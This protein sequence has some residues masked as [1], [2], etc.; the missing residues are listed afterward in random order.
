MKH[1]SLLNANS[2][3]NKN[4]T[5]STQ[6]FNA[7]ER[8][9]PK[10]E[11]LYKPPPQDS[12][13][14]P[15][16]REPVTFAN[17]A[18]T[19]VRPVRFESQPTSI[20]SNP[21]QSERSIP[22][23]EKEPAV[24]QPQPPRPLRYAD[25]GGKYLAYLPGYKPRDYAPYQSREFSSYSQQKPKSQGPWRTMH[26]Q[27]REYQQGE[28]TNQLQGTNEQY[29]LTNIPTQLRDWDG[30]KGYMDFE[31]EDQEEDE[32]Q[33][34][35]DYERELDKEDDEDEEC[36]ESFLL[37]LADFGFDYYLIGEE[38]QDEELQDEI[39][40][41]DEDQD[42]DLLSDQEDDSDNNQ[43]DFRFLILVLLFV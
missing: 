13:Y 31:D 42:D 27:T 22:P 37:I 12:I 34:D 19:S 14:N 25:K 21:F 17:Y 39:E 11:V 24:F 35:F 2:P 32:D 4:T 41:D 43:D 28:D 5:Y 9:A 29:N 7:A 10:L 1:L 33:D 15:P 20:K 8:G 30:Q 18:R 36:F 6:S 26:E 16:T 38:D 3:N 40:E 23:P